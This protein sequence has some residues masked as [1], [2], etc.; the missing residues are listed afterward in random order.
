[1]AKKNKNRNTTAQATRP[2]YKK[3]SI[4]IPLV[5]LLAAA[6]FRIALP[7]IVKNYVNHVLATLP[8]YHGH[9]ENIHIALIRG[10]YVID[11]LYLN[12]GNAGSE[13][14]FLHF[15]KTDISLEW[16]AL[17]NGRI[18]SEIIMTRPKFTY[19]FEDQQSSTPKQAEA[20]DWS[21][22]LTDLVP[23]AI[24]RL[25]IHQGKA[26]FVQRSA[27]PNIDLYLDNI[28]LLATNLRN[29]TGREE[30]LPSRL[31]ATAVSIGKGNLS[32]EGRLNLVKKI[33]DIDVSFAL[34]KAAAPAFN[35][36]TKHYAAID[37]EKGDFSIF[38]EMAIAE[39]YLTGYIKPLLKNSGLIG[40]ED[41][42]LDTLWE[43]FV[44]FFKF[45]L[46]NKGNNTLATK[47]PIQGNLNE[48]EGKVW[49]TVFNLMKN[50]WIKAFTS[51]T[52]HSISF[53]KA[54]EEKKIPPQQ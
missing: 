14:P 38:G 41:H 30:K 42:F 32:L 13:I 40:P 11:H 29:V 18:V 54:L 48:V 46:K 31:S 5:L 20:E 51:S 24:N 23:I 26:A 28:D 2:W 16:K 53:E 49:P 6:G 21:K 25:A 44:G 7:Y 3:K 22:A 39:G 15:E 34:E 8:G 52:D 9:V 45:I 50:G 37:F 4:W 36:F 17:F 10:A 33:P 43:G 1:M 19:V 12:K 27:E 47:V 35:A